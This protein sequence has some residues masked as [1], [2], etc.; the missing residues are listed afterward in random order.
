VRDCLG[1]ARLFS[2]APVLDAVSPP[3]QCLVVVTTC[4]KFSRTVEANL[5]KIGSD[6][7]SVWPLSGSVGKDKGDAVF[8][9]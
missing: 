1:I 6:I 4:I 5:N 9:H 7:F 8:A 2:V 3:I